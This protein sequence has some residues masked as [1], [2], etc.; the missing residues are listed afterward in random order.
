MTTK[1]TNLTPLQM[2]KDSENYTCLISSEQLKNNL[3][4][5]FIIDIRS[6]EDSKDDLIG[7]A[8]PCHWH[9]VCQLHIKKQLPNDKPIAVVCYTGQS[10]MHVAVLLTLLGYKAYSL[11]DGMEKWTKE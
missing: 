5:Y 8:L 6:L 2:L 4:D 7:Q 11:L 10:S 3:K 9:D 1:K